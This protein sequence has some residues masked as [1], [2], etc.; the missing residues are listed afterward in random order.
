MK[1]G[2]KPGCK[3]QAGLCVQGHQLLPNTHYIE[4]LMP[5]CA[6]GITEL[7]ASVVAQK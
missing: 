5:S 6:V 1:G 3:G 4:A 2:G 7:C